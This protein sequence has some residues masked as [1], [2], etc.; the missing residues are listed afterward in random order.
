MHIHAF[1]ALEQ[2]RPLVPWT[3]PSSAPQPNEVLVK[4]RACGLCHSD[5][6]M[7]DNDWHQSHFPLVP[8]H[9]V[10]GEVAEAGSNVSHLRPGTRVGVGW[11]RSAC[12]HCTDCLRGNENLCSQATGL[13]SHGHGGFADH[14]I[15]DS[16]FCFPLPEDLP[17]D[18]AGPLLC[19]GITVYSGLRFAGMSSG[20]RIG[21]IGVG[22]LGHLAVQFAH[23]LGNDVTVFTTTQDKAET[24][25]RLGAHDAILVRRSE[26]SRLPDKPFDLI[27][28]TVPAAIPCDIYLNLLGSDGVLCFVGVPSESLSIPLFP[29]LVKRRRVMASPIGGRAMMQEMLETAARFGVQPMIERF[30]LADVN[31]AVAKVRHNAIRYRAVLLA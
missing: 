18:L 20:Q 23:K 17:T 7:I 29:L 30:P 12:L 4:V 5:L 2:G 13:I 15:V 14:L 26:F 21:I 27:L 22:G 25:G 16:R 31:T 9:E 3:Y 6:H 24:A 1:A 8:G 28:S 11:Q 10:V 19:G